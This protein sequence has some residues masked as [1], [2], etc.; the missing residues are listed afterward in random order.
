MTTL[1]D[2]QTWRGKKMVDADGD[3]VGT[4]EEVYLDRQTGEPEWAAVKTGLFGTKLSF[5]PIRDAQMTDDG[6][7][8]VPFQKEQIKDAPR[9]EADGMLSAEEERRLYEHYGRSDYADYQGEDR[10]TALGLPE[11]RE[12][13]FSRPGAGEGEGDAEGVEPAVVGVRLRRVVVI[14]APDDTER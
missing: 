1:Q 2:I 12:G 14:A 10:T 8:R 13:R 7:I 3:K 11:E 6:E 4:I 5:V 9:V